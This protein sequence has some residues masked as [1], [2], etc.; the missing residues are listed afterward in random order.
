MLQ[1][2]LAATVDILVPE[3]DLHNLLN[4]G[5]IAFVI[6]FMKRLIDRVDGIDSHMKKQDV[7]IAEM[8]T[9]IRI[10]NEGK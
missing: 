1:Q 5:G 8:R 7:D 4:T 9:E 10:R 3:L 2:I 6:W